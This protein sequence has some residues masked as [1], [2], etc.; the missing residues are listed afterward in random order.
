MTI[1]KWERPTGEPAARHATSRRGDEATAKTDEKFAAAR[2]SLDAG[3]L[4]M[5]TSIDG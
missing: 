4:N 1:R 3:A 2:V 5:M